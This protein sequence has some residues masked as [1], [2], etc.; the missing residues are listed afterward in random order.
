MHGKVHQPHPRKHKRDFRSNPQ[1]NNQSNNQTNKQ[2]ND[3]CTSTKR[4][5]HICVL[6]EVIQSLRDLLVIAEEQ[7]ALTHVDVVRLRHL[8]VEPDQHTQ[9]LLAKLA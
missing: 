2:T 1:S 6:D 9:N 4:T 8:S 5:Y 7:E 3:R